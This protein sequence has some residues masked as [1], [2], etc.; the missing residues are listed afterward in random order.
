M[1]IEGIREWMILGVK[2]D[3]VV[4]MPQA[5]HTMSDCDCATAK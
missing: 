3:V 1:H 4:K 5:S 2:I